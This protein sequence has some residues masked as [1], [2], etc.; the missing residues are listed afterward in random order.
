MD[1]QRAEWEAARRCCKWKEEHQARG[2]VLL[3]K[4]A[5]LP[6]ALVQSIHRHSNLAKIGD[7]KAA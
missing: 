6:Y 7:M 4:R 5:I 3:L 1:L 2:R